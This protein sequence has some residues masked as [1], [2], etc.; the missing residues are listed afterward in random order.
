MTMAKK[1][2]TI[3]QKIIEQDAAPD[4]EG[5]VEV[6]FKNTYIGNLGVFYKKNKYILTKRLAEILK[7]DIGE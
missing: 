5:F 4:K 1:A 7:E 6:V 2:D 3:E